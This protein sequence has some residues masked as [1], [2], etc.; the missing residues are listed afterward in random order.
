MGAAFREFGRFLK[1]QDLFADA[2]FDQ[3]SQA[4]NQAIDNATPAKEGYR[5]ERML[6]SAESELARRRSSLKHAHHYRKIEYQIK[7]ELADYQPNMW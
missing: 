5:L 7:V 3:F 2:D 4:L 6:H 1:R